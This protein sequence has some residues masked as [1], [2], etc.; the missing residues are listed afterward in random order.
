MRTGS[1]D[2]HD[3]VHQLDTN[4]DNKID[5]GEFITATIN[6]ARLLSAENLRIA[7]NILDTDGNGVISKE[8]LRSVFHGAPQW[9]VAIEEVDD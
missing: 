3:L 7:F 5:Y 6:R 4:H 1:Q 8:E 2:W 9:Y